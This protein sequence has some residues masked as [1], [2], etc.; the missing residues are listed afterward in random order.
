MKKHSVDQYWK[1]LD[2][3]MQM[4][5]GAQLMRSASF[6]TEELHHAV[7]HHTLMES[8]ITELMWV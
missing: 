1:I 8:S 2:Y 7:L 6:P 5:L 4:Y 3:E